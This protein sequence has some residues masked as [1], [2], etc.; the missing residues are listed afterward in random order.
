MKKLVALLLL[1]V[2]INCNLQQCVLEVVKSVPTFTFAVL[3][4]QNMRV[5]KGVRKIVSQVISVKNACMDVQ[6]CLADAQRRCEQENSQGCEQNGLIMYPKCQAG[7]SNFGCCVC[8][9]NCPAGYRDDGAF[10]AKPEAYGR[11]AGYPWKFGDKAFNY[12]GAK[13]RCENDHGSCEMDGLIYYPRCRANFHKV[14]CC[15]CSPDC[16]SGMND[17]GVSCEKKSYG[18]GVGYAAKFGDCQDMKTYY[19]LNTAASCDE[20]MAQIQRPMDDYVKLVNE[21]KHERASVVQGRIDE[22]LKIFET[23]C[24]HKIVYDE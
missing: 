12:D 14:G 24:P 1:V 19:P 4:I 21:E 3:S 5:I 22:M 7:Y 23:T 9:Q 18:R 2:V 15:V 20:Q 13:R 10:C 16:P 17:I 8:S 11:G 6:I